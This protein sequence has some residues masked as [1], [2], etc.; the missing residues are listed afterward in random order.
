MSLPTPYWIL[1]DEYEKTGDIRSGLNATVGY[2]VPWANADAFAYAA[3][4]APSANHIGGIIFQ[5]PYK[6]PEPFAGRTTFLYCQGFKIKPYAP[7]GQTVTIDTSNPG[8]APGDFFQYAKVTLSF[9][10]ITFLN[11][12]G[13]DPQGLNQLDPSNPITGCEQSVDIN[14]KVITQAGS[15]YTYDTTGKPV[16]GDV[17]INVNEVKLMLRFPRVPY[18]PWQLVQPYVGKINTPYS[19]LR[20][21]HIAA[22]R[23]DYGHRP[24]TR[25][26]TRAKSRAQVRFQSRPD[27]DRNTG[28]D[29]NSFPLPD[30][31]GY[32]KITSVSGSK[33]PYTYADFG[34]I[35]T[36][37][38]F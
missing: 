25:R 30:G 3:L 12:E 29:W 36:D 23:N 22:G 16:Q 4:A 7:N 2:L 34:A 10:T 19:R 27:I 14:G 31:S 15:G 18:L 28:L 20:R 13:D 8:L 38:E 21:G 35:F 11:F 33:R 32:S 5:A 17:G 26:N 6:F 1:P 9:S 24:A 37:L